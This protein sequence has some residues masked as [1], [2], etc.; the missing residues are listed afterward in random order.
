ML[1]NKTETE[2]WSILK[3]EIESIIDQFGSL[4][5]KE[6]CLERNNCQ[7]KLLAK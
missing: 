3:Y 6:D 4:K 1:R 2:C 5:N 7:K